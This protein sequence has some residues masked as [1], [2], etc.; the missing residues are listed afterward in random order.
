MAATGF[1]RLELRIR[2][3]VSVCNSRLP[4]RRKAAKDSE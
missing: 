3:Q 1:P 4:K 2:F